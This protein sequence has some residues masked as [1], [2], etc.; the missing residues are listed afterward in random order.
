MPGAVGRVESIDEEG[1]ADG[2]ERDAGGPSSD[3]RD[4]IRGSALAAQDDQDRRDRD[5]ADRDAEGIHER[6]IDRLI[7]RLLHGSAR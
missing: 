1:G 5:R 6:M 7:L 3:E 4:G 2:V